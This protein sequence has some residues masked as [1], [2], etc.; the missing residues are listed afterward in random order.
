MHQ[1][2]VKVTENFNSKYCIAVGGCGSVYKAFLSAGQVVAVK[3][4]QENDEPASQEAFTCEVSVLTT[5]RNRNIIKHYGFCSH[6]RHS[7]L[8]Y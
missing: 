8:L 7:F 5:A 1:E 3:K 6:A 2:I 4:F